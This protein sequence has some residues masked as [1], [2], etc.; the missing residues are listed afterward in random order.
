MLSTQGDD[1]EKVIAAAGECKRLGIT[2]QAPDVNRSDVGFS[3]VGTNGDQ[4]VLFGLGAIKNVGEGAARLVVAER[5]KGG[6]FKSLDDLCERVDLRTVNKR[7]L[8]ALAK[9]GALDALGPRER[10][11][12]A[13]DRTIA[14]AQMVQKAAG[15]GQ[16]SLFG[17]EMTAST[18][19]ALPSV[20]PLSDQQRLAWEKESLG[21]FLSN[22][23]FERAARHLASKVTANSSQITEEMKGERVTVAGCV[24]SVRKVITKRSETMCIAHIEDLHGSIEVV[25]FPRTYQITT[26]LWRED[27]IVVVSGKVDLRQSGGGG[28]EES[29]GSAEV[30]ADF[31]EEWV[32]SGEPEPE[33]E[34]A[35]PVLLEEPA[36]EL[37][38]WSLAEMGPMPQEPPDF[39][40]A[41]APAVYEVT[42][43]PEPA[44][45][46]E[47]Q[48]EPAEPSPSTSRPSEP[49]ASTPEPANLEPSRP[50]PSDSKLSEPEPVAAEPAPGSPPSEPVRVAVSASYR[51]VT[52]VFNESGDRNA[53]LSRLRQLHATLSKQPGQVP[54][55]LAV[56]GT[57]GRRHV[58]GPTLRV[59]YTEELAQTVEHLLGPGSIVTDN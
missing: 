59:Q 2:L 3:V 58:A 5:V 51:R 16:Q 53:D 39:D 46:V 1:T 55:V 29:R 32:P 11:H 43:P 8:E 42:P 12:A 25:V 24:M 14:A 27:N 45:A 37:N 44:G 26:D 20:L 48:L 34:A 49:E 13:I 4:A 35:P 36:A 38:D 7:V 30:L 40:I 54:Y 28:D 33:E 9:A 50:E 23:P 15:I 22:H 41:E 56:V 18:A 47:S 6:P 57:E 21:F 17:G 31:A 10:V 52:I 19:S